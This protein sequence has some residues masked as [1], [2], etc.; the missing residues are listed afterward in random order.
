MP[1]KIESK[2]AIAYIKYFLKESVNLQLKYSHN[3]LFS[4]TGI[5]MVAMA[6]IMIANHNLHNIVAVKETV[7]FNNRNPKKIP[8]CGFII[9]FLFKYANIASPIIHIAKKNNEQAN[10]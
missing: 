3:F 1:E 2:E 10:I 4:N 8:L 5:R 9:S 6:L 7:I